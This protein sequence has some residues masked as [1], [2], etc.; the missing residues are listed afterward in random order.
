[1]KVQWLSFAPSTYGCMIV[2]RWFAAPAFDPDTIAGEVSAS[3][4]LPECLIEGHGYHQI[5]MLSR[6][7]L[8]ASSSTA[9]ERFD[10]SVAALRRASMAL[11]DVS[12]MLRASGIDVPDFAFDAA[13]VDRLTG[14]DDR[15]ARL[16]MT[17]PPLI[18][19][20]PKS[21]SEFARRLGLS[22][23]L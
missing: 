1:M 6:P 9:M 22:G 14:T 19:V 20:M 5:S 10:Q 11:S 4:I 17:A 12:A 3:T 13:E 23:K 7:C 21:S 16:R 8:I 2:R 15:A 18:G